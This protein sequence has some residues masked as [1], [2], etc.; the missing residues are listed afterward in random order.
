MLEGVEHLLNPFGHLE[1]V[2]I[3]HRRNPLRLKLQDRPERSVGVDKDLVLLVVPSERKE[4]VEKL[5]ILEQP[6]SR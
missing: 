5:F 3:R 4:L 6:I 2:C 1:G